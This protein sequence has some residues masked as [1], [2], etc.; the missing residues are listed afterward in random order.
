MSLKWLV[1]QFQH[2]GA[3]GAGRF[4]K[5]IPIQ[6]FCEP[7]KLQIVKIV[8]VFGLNINGSAKSRNSKASVCDGQED[9]RNRKKSGLKQ[10][11]TSMSHNSFPAI[12]F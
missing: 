7:P 11:N 4:R 9:L 1:E 6:F 12:F 5:I 10:A 2:T 8:Y 3:A